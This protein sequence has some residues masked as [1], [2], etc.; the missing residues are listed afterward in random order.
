MSFIPDESAK[1]DQLDRK[2]YAEAFAKFIANGGTP[3]TIGI[4]GPWGIG[5]TSFMEHIKDSLDET[6][7]PVWFNSW[8]HQCDE[9]PAVSMLFA[10]CQ[11]SGVQDNDVKGAFSEMFSLFSHSFL[12]RTLKLGV[13]DIERIKTINN[14]FSLDL[15]K[16]QN[17]LKAKYEMVIAASLKRIPAQ[18]ICFFIDDLDRCVPDRVVKVLESIKL[19]L[20][21][22]NC[23]FVVGVDV[24]QVS[25]S[26]ES[27]YGNGYSE[28]ENYLEKII[29]VPFSIPPIQK[30]KSIEYLSSLLPPEVTD[31]SELALPVLGVN[32]RTIKRFANIFLL[33]HDM[34]KKTVDNYQANVLCACLLVQQTSPELYAELV[35]GDFITPEDRDTVTMRYCTISA[36]W[37]EKM[38]ESQLD[39][40]FN[41]LIFQHYDKIEDYIHMIAPTSSENPRD[42]LRMQDIVRVEDIA[43]TFRFSNKEVIQALRSVGIQAKSQKT[44]IKPEDFDEAILEIERIRHSKKPFGMQLKEDVTFRR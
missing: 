9:N 23:I 42:R 35:G 22:D 25:K 33:Y 4:H 7:L 20:N 37:H 41:N 29:Q 36:R 8:E 39:E 1:I 32:P 11:A 38:K 30:A 14:D 10:L 24:D 3:I 27:H 40:I 2:H 5:K 18:R 19:F 17:S 26:I 21:L 15:I 6:V 43:R 31:C 34:A 28:S 12:K 13:D 44:I 16:I